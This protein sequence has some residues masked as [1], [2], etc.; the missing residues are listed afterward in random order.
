MTRPLWMLQVVLRPVPRLSRAAANAVADAI[1]VGPR[2]PVVEDVLVA[3]DHIAG[4]IT[5][6]II[7]S[8]S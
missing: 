2:D 1:M 8:P 3:V 7:V 4:T 5:V 6:D